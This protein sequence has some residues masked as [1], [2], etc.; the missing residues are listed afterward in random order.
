MGTF[1]AMPREGSC[2]INSFMFLVFNKKASNIFFKSLIIINDLINFDI[3]KNH[4][5][6]LIFYGSSGKKWTTEE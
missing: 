4:V 3:Q 6:T 1:S 2:K 5:L